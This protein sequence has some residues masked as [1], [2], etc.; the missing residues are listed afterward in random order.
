MILK[1]TIIIMLKICICYCFVPY[2]VFV[3][4]N[5][6]DVFALDTVKLKLKWQHQF[7]FAGYYA[8]KERGYYQDVGIDVE[9][10]EASKNEQDDPIKCVLEG[11]ADFGI[12]ATDLVIARA[13]GKPV[14]ALAAIFQHSPLILL[15]KKNR[16]IR[17][18]HDLIGKKI[19]LE[20][21]SEEIEAYLNVEGV[22]YDQLIKVSHRFDPTP[23]IKDE[24]DAMSAY[25]SD[26]PYLLD[27]EKIKY[28]M[29]SP[30]SCGIDFY[31]D[32]LFTS[33]KQIK[34]FPKRVKSFLEA[35][36]RG[37]E[38]ALDH[39]D[40][41]IQ[42]IYNQYSKRHDLEHLKYE[43][44]K[45]RG[46]IKPSFVQIGYMYLDRWKHIADTYAELD[47]IAN[48]YTLDG[49]LFNRKPK[50]LT[51]WIDSILTGG[52]VILLLNI[53]MIFAFCMTKFFHRKRNNN[54]ARSE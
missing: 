2:F 47:M 15:A 5:N 28:H 38:Y 1:S 6:N 16:S 12:A 45:M 51:N 26:E 50:T 22:T 4:L 54:S 24:I 7:Q 13:K 10:I 48:D 40:E 18:I 52:A 20:P 34:K 29:F 42:L 39:P 8:A 17:H 23:L 9:I 33:E 53:L 44:E 41:I 31:E 46:L 25:G 3:N 37:W 35:S 19:M 30:R 49:F 43:A 14:V 36:L 11:E 27:K 32:I 21:H